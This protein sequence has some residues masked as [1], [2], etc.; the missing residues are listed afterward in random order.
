MA[1]ILTQKC[2]GN[3]KPSHTRHR[4]WAFT[5]F[6]TDY[7]LYVTPLAKYL[8]I[9]QEICPKTKRKHLQGYV[10]LNEAKTFS[11]IKKHYFNRGEH[12]EVARGTHEDNIKYC[13]KDGKYAEW[14]V[15][16]KQGARTDLCAI[17]DELVSGETTIDEIVLERPDIYH[18]Y[19]RTLNAIEERVMAGKFRTSMTRGIWLWGKT[20]TG[21]SHIALEKFTPETHYIVPND[22]GWWDNY[23]QQKYVVINDFRGHISYNELLQMVDKW[24]YSVKRR[25]KAPLP[26]TSEFVI[27]TSSLPPDKVYHNRD[28][29]DKIEQLHR[30]FNIYNID[31]GTEKLLAISDLSS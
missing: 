5:S 12:F 1:E 6:E 13:S 3:T 4:N 2:S 10:H 27:I 23:R 22:N 18:Q 11:Y 26:F 14:G 21:K 31:I 16:P 17:K 15:K 24:P 9:G 8:I 29:E 20:G 7:E 25:G 28:E 19:G 30:R